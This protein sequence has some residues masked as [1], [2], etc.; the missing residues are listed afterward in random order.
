MFNRSVQELPNGV[1]QLDKQSNT[2]QLFALNRRY[3]IA[4]YLR[5][6]CCFNE[7][8]DGKE[9]PLISAETVAVKMAQ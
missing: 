2:S 7:E 5:Q 9:C 8:V 6:I 1:Q 3:P 4:R